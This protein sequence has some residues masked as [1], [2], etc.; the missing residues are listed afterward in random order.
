[1][2]LHGTAILLGD[3]GVLIRG[4]SG[5]G[6]TTLALSLIERCQAMN[7]FASLVC[8]DQILLEA[9]DGRLVCTAP[10]S[11]AGLAEFRGLGPSRTPFEPRM[12][13]DLVV[14]LVERELAPRY[15]KEDATT[16]MGCRV[17]H[18]ALP[19]HEIDGPALAVLR[20]LAS[21]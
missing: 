18:L 7:R 2:N 17:P 11:I 21:Q 5:A 12:V 16:L 3:K 6:K 15:P 1:M 10:E 9:H 14:D 8:D 19:E 20:K 4:R 13:V